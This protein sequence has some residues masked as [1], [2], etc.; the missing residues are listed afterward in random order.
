MHIVTDRLI[1]REF[2]ASD[3]PD[4][5]A[6]QSD[7]RYLRY[8]YW[9]ARTEEDVREFV[10]MF[11]R[12]RREEPRSRFQLAIT[13]RGNEGVVI[14]NCGIRRGDRGSGLA[15]IGYEIAPEFWGHGYA[16]EAARAM[17]GFA[18]DTLR[19]HRVWATCIAENIGSA[20]V[21][22]KLGMKLEGRLREH[23]WFKDRGWDAF[24]YGMLADEW[25]ASD[26]RNIQ[27]LAAGPPV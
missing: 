10:G 11:V 16:T 2:E 6:Y 17:L 21:M 26:R 7:P 3:W 8:Y 15:E 5:L 27:P 4:V 12:W 9:E 25:G 13:E 14:G 23:E 24:I 22:E 1:L 19:L 20:R 18:F